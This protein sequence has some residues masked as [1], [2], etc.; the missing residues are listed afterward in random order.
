M[1]RV[2]DGDYWFVIAPKLN[3]FPRKMRKLECARHYYREKFL[4][5]NGDNLG[6]ASVHMEEPF[7]L[8]P[9]TIKITPKPD[10]TGRVCV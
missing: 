4:P 5:F 1:A 7:P 3:S 10:R 2:D 9:L 6:G 8:E